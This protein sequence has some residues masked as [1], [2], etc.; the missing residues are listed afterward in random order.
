MGGWNKLEISLA[1]IRLGS[2]E[3]GLSLSLAKVLLDEIVLPFE[4]IG[5]RL[6]LL[7]QKLQ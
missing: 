3:S 5:T 6:S 7:Y 4:R 2:V 1:L